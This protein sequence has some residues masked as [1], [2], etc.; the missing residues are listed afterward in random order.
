MKKA[1]NKSR[2][3]PK[4]DPVPPSSKQCEDSLKNLCEPGSLFVNE[5]HDRAK[6]ITPLLKEILDYRPQPRWP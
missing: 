5:I 6:V 4:T 3:Q 1:S 2:R